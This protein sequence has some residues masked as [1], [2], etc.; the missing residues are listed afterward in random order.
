MKI[1]VASNI[2]VDF[3]YD[4]KGK[5]SKSLGGP[6]CYCGLQSKGVKFVIF[7]DL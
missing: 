5:I 4:I 1:A 2:V 3:I 7:T 6:A